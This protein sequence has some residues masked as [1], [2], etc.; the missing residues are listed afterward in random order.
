MV[1]RKSIM[2]EL[3]QEIILAEL[4]RSL[5]QI[6]EQSQPE[7]HPATMLDDLP[8]IDSL[9]LLQAVAYLEQHFRVEIDVVALDDLSSVQDILNA[10]SRA[11][12][13]DEAGRSLEHVSN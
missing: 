5:R 10:I 9:R 1:T 11:R 4:A 6:C 2:T 3:C 12:P 8:G 7:L 13:A